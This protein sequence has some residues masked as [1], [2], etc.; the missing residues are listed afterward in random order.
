MALANILTSLELGMTSFDSSAG[1]LGGCPYAAGASGNVATEDLV[2][3]MHSLGIKTGVD[4][5]KLT[6]ASM[7]I[8]SHLKR[9]SPSKY[10]KAYLNT[11][12]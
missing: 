4:L 6:E 7:F 8:L 2:Y 9:E 10:L 11:G 3:L 1:G 5:K 12:Y